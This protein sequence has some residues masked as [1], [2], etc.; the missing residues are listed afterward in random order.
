MGRTI[1]AI[2]NFYGEAGL[3]TNSLRSG[4]VP[5]FLKFRLM[6]ARQLKCW[7]PSAATIVTGYRFPDLIRVIC[8]LTV[9]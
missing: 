7:M 1:S 8:G 6:V 2:R 9:L 5:G 4:G 3:Q